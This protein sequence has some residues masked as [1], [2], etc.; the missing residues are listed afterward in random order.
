[1]KPLLRQASED[2][3]IGDSRN[4]ALRRGLDWLRGVAWP[5]WAS[6]ALDRARGGFVERFSLEGI[7][8]DPG[9]KRARVAA[10]QVYVF[11]H[12]ALLGFPGA[13]EI[14][15]RGYAFLTD[16]YLL[17]EGVWARRVSTCGDPIDVRQDLYDLAF[18]LFALSWWA[19]ASNDKGVIRLARETLAALK[20]R[21]AHPA[22]RG[23]RHSEGAEA[24]F[25]Q[26]PHMHLLEAMIC[27]GEVSGEDVFVDEAD[28][29]FQLAREVFVGEGDVLPELFDEDWAPEARPRVEPGHHFE[30]TWL[31]MRYRDLTGAKEALPLAR[32]LFEFAV[33]CGSSR[34]TGLVFDAVDPTG[35]PVDADH[36]I[37]PQLEA[38]KAWIAMEEATGVASEPAVAALLDRILRSYLE[39]AHPGLWIDH[40]TKDLTP[41][42][43]FAPTSTLY[44]IFLALSEVFKRAERG[45]LPD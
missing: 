15:E 1:M 23:Y 19:R 34:Q 20:T 4:A 9:F 32:R 11:S 38:V 26:N 24:P 45:R 17:S 8:L 10:R 22:G 27:L 31:L 13:I 2:Q 28:D 37:W 6:N 3:P 41:K 42:V 29:L 16:K 30:W 12:A 40:V 44:H 25:E 5:F 7:P 14:A 35:A 36:R 18:I 21:L 39:P 43:E 33:R